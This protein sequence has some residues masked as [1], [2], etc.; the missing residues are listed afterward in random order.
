MCTQSLYLNVQSVEGDQFSKNMMCLII[1][2]KYN[3][4]RFYLFTPDNRTLPGFSVTSNKHAAALLKGFSL[5]CKP[6]HCLHWTEK[7]L[8]LFPFDVILEIMCLQPWSHSCCL[9]DAVE[10]DPGWG[11]GD[12][13]GSGH[14]DSKGVVVLP[15]VPPFPDG[16]TYLKI[17]RMRGF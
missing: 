15:A 17:W 1:Q 9:F 8:S 4:R 7:R 11:C 13:H 3:F 14:S 5:F 16:R 2:L 6:F 10:A 12:G